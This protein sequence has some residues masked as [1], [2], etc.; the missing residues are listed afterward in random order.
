M[1]VSS[2]FACAGR[3]D[4]KVG[5]VNV[6][7]FMF[8]HPPWVGLPPDYAGPN[9]I[10]SPSFVDQQHFVIGK[11][12]SVNHNLCCPAHFIP[13]TP[14]EMPHKYKATIPLYKDQWWPL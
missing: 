12:V 13:A 4:H 9:C 7:G 11:Y 8:Q 2:V 3:R 5:G 14:D 6:E 1:H 10:Q